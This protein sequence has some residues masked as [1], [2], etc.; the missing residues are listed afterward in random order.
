[1]FAEG[2]NS[3]NNII[4]IIWFKLDNVCLNFARL[5]TRII[6]ERLVVSTA[7][8]KD[9][10][11]GVNFVAEINVIDFIS[12]SLVHISLSKDSEH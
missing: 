9:T 12:I 11:M 7:Y 5:G 4:Y 1:L 2:S 10:F 8:S 3:S 6:I